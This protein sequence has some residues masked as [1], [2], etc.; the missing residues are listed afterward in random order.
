MRSGALSHTFGLEG[1]CLKNALHTLKARIASARRDDIPYATPSFQAAAARRQEALLA[2]LRNTYSKHGLVLYL[3][4]GV[5]AS[6]GFPVWNELVMGMLENVFER[7]VYGGR[8][9]EFEESGSWPWN[10]KALSKAMAELSLS[11]R[12]PVIMLARV[13]RGYYKKALASRVAGS[14]YFQSTL[15]QWL[16]DDDWSR[17]FARGTRHLDVDLMSS[18]LIDAIA[19]ATRR[20]EYA[21]IRAIVNYNFDDLV[22]EVI[23]QRGTDCSTLGGPG[24]RVRPEALPCY[25]VHGVVP[26]RAYVRAIVRRRQHRLLRG[27]FVFSEEEY[28]R[29]YSEPFRWSNLTQ[30]S[31]LGTH[32]GLFLGLSME[33]PNLRRLLDGVHR[34]YPERRNY[35]VLKRTRPLAKA[36]RNVKEVAINM[37]EDIE[38]DAFADIG[39]HVVWVDEYDE[40]TTLL[41]A[42]ANVDEP[43]PGGSNRGVRPSRPTRSSRG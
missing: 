35:A 6:A 23:R 3:G 31:L 26:L 39:V 8:E 41:R 9:G 21:G 32:D 7:K 42:V 25:H 5:S 33:D 17:A 27:D 36:R 1:V 29:Q 18:P 19:H 40:I 38:S 13:L 34:Q 20:G 2:R 4:A 30:T 12:R 14:L 22:D 43:R 37:L 24:D 11:T 28:H 16:V 10:G 15:G